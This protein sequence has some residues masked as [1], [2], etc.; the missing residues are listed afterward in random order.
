M[1]HSSCA[2]KIF[3]CITVLSSIMVSQQQFSFAHVSDTHIGSATAAEDL[4]RTVN[5]LN[6][7]NKIS[8]VLIT[9]DIT[10]YGSDDQLRLAKQILDSLIIPWY[11]VPGNHDMKWSE[12]G[13]SSFAKIFGY[14]RFVFDTAGFRFIGMHQGPRMRM[15]DGYWA[16]E[17]IS[18][19][20]SLVQHM[21]KK[22][23]PIFFVTH[24]PADSGIS[25]WYVMTERLKK[26]NTQAMLNGHWHQNHYALFE[27]IPGVVGR[28]NLR[29]KESFGGYN[30]VTIRNDSMIYATR[31]PGTETKKPWT[32]VQLGERKYSLV[33]NSAVPTPK[34]QSTN[35]RWI[36]THSSS[37]T[38]SPTV[39]KNYIAA[40]YSDGQV[41]VRTLD[42][43]KEIFSV[44]LAGGVYSS[45]AMDDEHI[46][47][48]SADSVVY[49]FSIPMKKLRWKYKTNAAIVATPTIHLG[50]VFTGA[51]D[52]SFRAINLKS[53]KLMWKFDSLSG[54]V[55]SKPTV[56]NGMVI[57][58]AWD[59][60][61]YC[62]NEKNGTLLW[63]WNGDK[64][65]TLLS[66]AVCEPVYAHGKIFIVAPDRFVTA[67]DAKTGFQLWRTNRFQVRETIGLSEDGERVYIRTMNDS[68][69][70]LSTTSEYPEIIWGIHAGFGYDINSAQI[71]EKDGVLFYATMKG[72]LYAIEGNSGK[73]LRTFK[74]DNVIA[75]TPIPLSN[76][77]V[78]L[79][80]IKGT[81]MDVAWKKK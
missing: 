48:T 68:L 35:L 79:S 59:E 64:R 80:N 20:D 28:S 4:R 22:R 36:R 41:I 15:G 8:F 49:C 9:G 34:N 32:A 39:W 81:I 46:V 44:S 61:L 38:S 2:V 74:E 3:L 52:R 43:G 5:D 23:Q 14:E 25:N 31:I 33:S 10:E 42:Y 78:I 19:F 24:Y 51:S 57:F 55:E 12:S 69:Y 53:G 16:P 71:K 73:I 26:L 77:R 45:P 75:H 62:L 17:D 66:P 60:H 7:L 11:I 21:P 29:G 58:G 67:L 1:S 50:V 18:W 6:V 70:A 54:F 65:G 27:G 63:K 76:E 47:I 37:M 13:G 56:V 40:A 72:L 30:I